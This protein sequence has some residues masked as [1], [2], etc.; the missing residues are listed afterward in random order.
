MLRPVAVRPHHSDEHGWESMTS[1]RSEMAASRK[2]LLTST[3][4]HSPMEGF[5]NPLSINP[6][7]HDNKRL[8]SST[9][10]TPPSPLS[11]AR[12]LNKLARASKRFELS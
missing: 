11:L 5:I 10:V 6:R 8:P 1:R 7:D 12:E 9:P 4:S 2:K 3:M